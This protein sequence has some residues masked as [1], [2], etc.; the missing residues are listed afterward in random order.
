M[1]TASSAARNCKLKPLISKMLLRMSV[2]TN[3]SGVRRHNLA[4]WVFG[5]FNPGGRAL[6]KAKHMLGIESVEKR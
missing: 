1:A 6:P 3:E 4:T 5:S 2:L